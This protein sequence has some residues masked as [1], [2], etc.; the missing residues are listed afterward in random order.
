MFGKLLSNIIFAFMQPGI[1]RAAQQLREDP[2]V[3][4]K[5]K[6]LEMA[7]QDLK[8]ATDRKNE[9]LNSQERKDALDYFGIKRVKY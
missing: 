8:D 1:N 6:E 5:F 2:D 9:F 3:K 7:L 4:Q